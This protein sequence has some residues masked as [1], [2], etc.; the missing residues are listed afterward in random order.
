METIERLLQKTQRRCSPKWSIRQI[1]IIG[2][3][4]RWSRRYA[5]ES[6]R[7]VLLCDLD[8]LSRCQF[9]DAG[10]R[11]AQSRQDRGYVG[12]SPFRG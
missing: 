12:K 1:R 9:I 2:S 5:P 3:Q 10:R 7:L 8:Y 6:A 4:R 11:Y